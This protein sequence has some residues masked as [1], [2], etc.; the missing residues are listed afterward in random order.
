[1]RAARCRRRHSLAAVTAPA[2]AAPAAGGTALRR[3]ASRCLPGLLPL[4]PSRA[5]A[6][7]AALMHV[8]SGDCDGGG[9]ADVGAPS[10]AVA[11]LAAAART[12]A[13]RALGSVIDVCARLAGDG[14]VDTARRVFD[15]LLR[16]A[17]RDAMPSGRVGGWVDGLVG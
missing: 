15:F 4:F 2:A 1:M 10:D 5:A 9:A 16:C 3:V 6:A 12:D 17:R 14:E 7:A 13:L 8:A 11:R